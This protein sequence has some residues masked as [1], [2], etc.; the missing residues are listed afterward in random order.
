METIIRFEEYTKILKKTEILKDISLEMKSGKLYKLKGTNG[1]GKTM[2]LRAIAGL[3]YPTTG[4]IYVND[5]EI[6]KNCTYPA[7]LGVLIENPSFWREYT[8]LEVLRYLASIKN[9]ITDEDIKASM[10]KMGLSPDD[11]R[12]I[13]K[14]SLGMKQKLGIIQAIMEK[15]DILLLDEP[16]NALDSETIRLFQK[17]IT[18]ERERGLLL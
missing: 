17:V 15:P 9:N 16:L 18:E 11:K 12:K 7:S 14:Y 1:S 10:E 3:I 6:K 5:V 13:G 2:L 8:G 4:A